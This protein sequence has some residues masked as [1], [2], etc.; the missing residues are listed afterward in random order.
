MLCSYQLGHFWVL[1]ELPRF[2]VVAEFL[3]LHWWK[4]AVWGVKFVVTHF[5]RRLIIYGE[6]AEASLVMRKEDK[7]R[8]HLLGTKLIVSRSQMA[9]DWPA[10]TRS[11]GTREERLISFLYAQE[12][13]KLANS[14]HPKT[15][16]QQVFWAR[17]LRD[18]IWALRCLFLSYHR[19]C[20]GDRCNL[21]LCQSYHPR[22][23]SITCMGLVMLLMTKRLR[24]E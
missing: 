17:R 7:S 11:W 3:Q 2:R 6:Y 12:A 19:Q 9:I 16:F 8:V 5:H 13:T 1:R 21:K 14:T 22:K 24:L 10:R 20:L 18:M 23:E 15:S 4:K